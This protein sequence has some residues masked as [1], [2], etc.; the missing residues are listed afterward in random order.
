[1]VVGVSGAGSWLAWGRLGA[2]TSSTWTPYTPTFAAASGGAALGNALLDA[3]YALRG[4]QCTVRIG[5]VAGTTTAFGSGGLR[6]GLPFTAAALP[7]AS[8][9]WTGSA[10][11]ADAGSTY[12]PGVCRILP[13]TSYVVGISPI[14]ATG[15]TAT[16]WRSI[17]PF[18]WGSTDY[19]S[20]GVTYK[21][22]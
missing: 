5:F 1:M 14:T 19:A 20:F 2:G 15:G 17:T 12:Y 11:C 16:E 7:S 18:T 21:I 13:N 4:D 8:M 22:A 9:F 6:W 3:E 10:M